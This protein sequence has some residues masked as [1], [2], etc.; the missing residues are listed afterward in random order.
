MLALYR[1]GRQ[2]E[3]LEAYRDARRAL[4]DGLGI[5]PGSVLQQLR[6]RSSSR[7]KRS[8]PAPP[9]ADEL[10]ARDRTAARARDGAGTDRGVARGRVSPAHVDWSGRFGKTRLALQAAAELVDEFADGVFFVALAPLGDARVV[11]G[12][13]AQAL[14]LRPDDDPYAYLAS[15]RLLLVLDNAEHLDGVEQIVVDM[16]VVRSS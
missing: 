13:A 12:A 14:G 11:P 3:A 10:A 15:R 6:R 2:A 1:S 8:M 9:E 7:T 5:E 16:L 4:V